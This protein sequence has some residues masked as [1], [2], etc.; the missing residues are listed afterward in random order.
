VHVPHP[1]GRLPADKYRG[2]TDGDDPAVCRHVPD[3]SRWL[4][5]ISF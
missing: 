5:H 3:P 1:S 2:A 4:W